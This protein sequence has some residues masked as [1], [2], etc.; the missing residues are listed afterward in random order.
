MREA[1]NPQGRLTMTLT[2]PRT[3]QVIDR[4]FARNLVTLSGRQ[5]LSDLFSGTIS[6]F[7]AVEVV[8]GNGGILG[9]EGDPDP[10]PAAPALEDESLA[11]DD[12]GG[13]DPAPDPII[14]EIGVPA[15]R[16][17]DGTN[18]MVTPVLATLEANPGGPTLYLR[19]A[20]IQF[21]L[22]AEGGSAT[23]L[24]NRVVFGL[25][26]KDPN[27]QLTLSWEIIF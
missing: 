16:D 1:F 19:E 10:P 8:V 2:D 25:I 22:P 24:Y 3:G 17:F 15:P 7:D 13:T 5:L 18:R 23:T 9:A 27:L 6:G 4:R 20:G 12:D 26:T 14:A 21:T 11:H